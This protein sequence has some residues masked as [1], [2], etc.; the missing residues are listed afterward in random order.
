M[1]IKLNPK[2]LFIILFLF[3]VVLDSALFTFIVSRIHIDNFYRFF[4]N[5]IL[6]GLFL[7]WIVLV[8][9]TIISYY[10]SFKKFAK[11]E[12][13]DKK[14]SIWAMGSVVV[15]TTLFVLIMPLINLVSV[16]PYTLISVDEN[17]ST[18]TAPEASPSSSPD[19][20]VSESRDN[21]FLK[22]SYDD[23]GNMDLYQKNGGRDSLIVQYIPIDPQR[24][25]DFY[26][27]SSN[28]KLYV[29]EGRGYDAGGNQYEEIAAY[30]WSGEDERK[31]ISKTQLYFA[32][33]GMYSATR[34]L[35]LAGNDLL[36]RTSG[37][38]GCG[39]WGEVWLLT[40]GKKNSVQEIGFG[41]GVAKDRPGYIGYHNGKVILYDLDD[42]EKWDTSP[43]SRIFSLDPHTKV[44]ETLLDKTKIDSSVVYVYLDEKEKNVVAMAAKNTGGEEYYLV[45]QKYNLDTKQIVSQ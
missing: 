28:K 39:G 25:I 18:N 19:V 4:E 9:P 16:S 29:V 13:N 23:L 5:S 3:F 7:F 8:I 1:S 20:K 31:L 10:L 30:T 38:D 14:D 26:Y 41:C 24:L 40:G 12:R 17:A 6:S 32:A 35:E 37:G 42:P 15:L 34:I 21:F 43:V 22:Q 27:D 2:I 33:P 44:T 45:K 36:L 11:E